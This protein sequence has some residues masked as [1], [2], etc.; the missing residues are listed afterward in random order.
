MMQKLR[1]LVRRSLESSPLQGNYK[2]PDLS[3]AERSPCGGLLQVDSAIAALHAD[4][5]ARNLAP[6]LETYRRGC[7]RT[8]GLSEKGAYSL[9]EEVTLLGGVA[10]I[11]EETALILHGK[12]VLKHKSARCE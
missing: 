8:L 4:L 9:R 12:E 1:V 7:L 3:S 2:L 6:P 5:E 11:H 10:F